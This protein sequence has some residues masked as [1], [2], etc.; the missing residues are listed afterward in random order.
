MTLSLVTVR[1]NLVDDSPLLSLDDVCMD[2]DDGS[3]LSF[4]D[5]DD[6]LGDDVAISDDDQMDG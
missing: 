3:L 1:C 6:M 5:P 4:E 2:G